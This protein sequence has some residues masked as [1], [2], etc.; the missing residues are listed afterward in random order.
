VVQ[1]IQHAVQNADRWFLAAKE[2]KP[3]VHAF[4]SPQRRATDRTRGGMG[5]DSARLTI[6]QPTERRRLQLTGGRMTCLERS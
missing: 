1:A 6:G 3:L 5:A 2:R 4:V